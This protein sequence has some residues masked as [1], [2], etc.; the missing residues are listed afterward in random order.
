MK[1]VDIASLLFG[2]SK[3]LYSNW[4]FYKPDHLLI[5]C[6]EG[7][8]SALGNGGYAIEKV[9][10]THGHIDHIAGLPTLLWS[11]AAGMGASDKPLTIY[12][13]H[14]DAYLADMIEYLRRTG[15]RLTYD[16]QWQSLEAGSE[17]ALRDKRRIAT[18]ATRHIPERLTLGYK[19]IETRRRLKAEYSHFTEAEIRARAQQNGLDAIDEIMQT[20]DATLM[21]FGGDGLPLNA[22]D[23]RDAEVLVHEATL[24]AAE[25]RKGERHSLLSEAVQV[26]KEANVQ[27]LVLQHVSGRYEKHD[28]EKATLRAVKQHEYSGA[29]WCLFHNRLFRIGE[30]RA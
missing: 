25:D 7:V 24:L 18:F 26:A 12:H 15:K 21:A 22:S 27:T 23:V 1:V 2:Y 9:L 19:I 16:L 10:L 4:I 11:R 17:F 30:P 3:A 5:D 20:Y 8:A 6:G 28:V 14:N 29:V 13:P